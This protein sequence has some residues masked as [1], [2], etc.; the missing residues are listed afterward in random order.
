MNLGSNEFFQRSFTKIKIWSVCHK[1]Q[2]Q[3]KQKN[4]MD[5]IIFE[6]NTAVYLH[7]FGIKYIPLEVLSKIKDKSILHKIFRIQPDYSIMWISLYCSH[8]IYACKKSYP[9]L[10]QFTFSY[11]LQKKWQDNKYFKDKYGKKD[12]SVVFR[13]KN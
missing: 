5:F 4:T 6:R 7:S 1:Y 8:R 10:Y 11:R 2:W 12:A 3:T 13:L 9:R